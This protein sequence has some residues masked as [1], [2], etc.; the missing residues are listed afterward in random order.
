VATIFSDGRN[1]NV[2]RRQSIVVYFLVKLL[3][4]NILHCELE[5][6]TGWS[7]DVID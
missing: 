5:L 3:G 6:E 1:R 4:S 7:I 2:Q